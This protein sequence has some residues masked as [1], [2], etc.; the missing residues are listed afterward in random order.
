M[1]NI[2]IYLT[3][4]FLIARR[5]EE[6]RVIIGPN[7]M[8][9]TGLK[10]G[11]HDNVYFSK[12]S[13]NHGGKLPLL[14]VCVKITHSLVQSSFIA[15]WWFNY[16]CFSWKSMLIPQFVFFPCLTRKE[17]ASLLV[18]HRSLLWLKGKLAISFQLTKFFC[19]GDI[20]KEAAS[21]VMR[22]ASKDGFLKAGHEKNF[23]PAI[24]NKESL[25]RASF[26]HMTNLKLVKK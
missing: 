19:S 13:Y 20:F 24:A 11:K 23:A 16:P 6:G 5:D 3:R 18:C 26:E 7:N 17:A 25:H 1:L 8:L 10:S 14:W 21:S 15:F 9:T 22:S 12:P 2:N 4:W